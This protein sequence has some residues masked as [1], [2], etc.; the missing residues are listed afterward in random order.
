MNLN[1]DKTTK[2][3]RL[4]NNGILLSYPNAYCAPNRLALP[5]AVRDH[6]TINHQVINISKLSS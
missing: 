1:N 2:H 5:A 6:P 4:K 3:K